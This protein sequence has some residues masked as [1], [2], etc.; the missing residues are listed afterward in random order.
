MEERIGN[1]YEGVISGITEW[2]IYVELHNTVEGMIHVSKI[3]GDYFFYNEE[4]Y[5]MTG[6]DTGKTFKL[7]EKVKIVVSGVDRMSKSID[8]VFAD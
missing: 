8:F 6:T 4:T 1:T 3:E 7:G 5:E 2:G